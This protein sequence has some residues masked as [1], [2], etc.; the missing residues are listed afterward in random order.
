MCIRDR[1]R[2][3]LG[4]GFRAGTTVLASV[5]D[6]SP[7]DTCGLAPDDE[8][9]A[10]ANLRVKAGNWQTTFHAVAQVGEPITLLVARKGVLQ[11]L[12]ATP[13]TGPGKVKLIV[14]GAASESQRAAGTA[15]MGQGRNN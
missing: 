12:Q 4:V 10:I 6:G 3:F 11:S 1:N 15:W 5:S 14:N 13:T 9:L 2:P 7:A 8:L